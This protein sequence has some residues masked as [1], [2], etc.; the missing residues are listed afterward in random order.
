M[1]KTKWISTDS[2]MKV[3]DAHSTTHER[4]DMVD[5]RNQFKELEPEILEAFSEILQTTAFINGPYVKSFVEEL[6]TY[7]GAEYLTPCGNGTDALQIAL[8]A[9][10]LKPGDEV[11]VPSFTFVA[12]VE[13]IGLMGLT[14]VLIDVDEHT[15]NMDAAQLEGA[16]SDRTRAIMPVH[17]FG[18]CVDMDAILDFARKHNLYVIEDNAQ[19]IGAAYTFA[20]GEK[21][22]SGTIGDLGCLSFYPSK[23]L[24]AYGDAGAIM[25]QDANLGALIHSVANHG[26]SKRYYHDRLGVNSRL[27]SFQAA[28]LKV[29]LARLDRYINARQTAAAYYDEHLASLEMLRLPARLP[30]STHVF[31]QYTIQL[32]EGDRDGLKEYLNDRGIPSMIYYPVPTQEQKA[33]A[34]IVKTPVSLDTTN[35]LCTRVLSLPMHSELTDSQLEYICSSIKGYFEG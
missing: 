12:S 26:M 3:S 10:N 16:L 4:I 31:H 29:K 14:P 11:I 21:K 18:Q 19:S 32:M 8:M 34:D 24:G 23:N 1:I 22:M 9:L 30:Q 20:S 28:V 7:L 17:L 35:A 25:T 33:F 5:L 2:I 15:F 27:D 6:K 13:V